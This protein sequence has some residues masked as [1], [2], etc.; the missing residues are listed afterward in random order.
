MG[1]AALPGALAFGLKPT[2]AA[3]AEFAPD[4]GVAWPGD[5]ADGLRAA[6]MGWQTYKKNNPLQTEEM[7]LLRDYLRADCK[8]LWQILRWLRSA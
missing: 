4:Y 5:L 6:V 3:L 1:P 7:A 8:A 2:A